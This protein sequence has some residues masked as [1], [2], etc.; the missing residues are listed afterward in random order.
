MKK[1]RLSKADIKN[2][3]NKI[4]WAHGYTWD[5]AREKLGFK[6]GIERTWVPAMEALGVDFSLITSTADILGELYG[7]CRLSENLKFLLLMKR[8]RQSEAAEKIG[9]GLSELSKYIQDIRSPTATSVRAMSKYFGIDP[10]EML[11][12]VPEVQFRV[13]S[14]TQKGE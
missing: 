13:T 8:V 2:N 6:I 1:K 11:F 3:L 7:E 12:G 10:V 9:I 14:R 4:L 5:D